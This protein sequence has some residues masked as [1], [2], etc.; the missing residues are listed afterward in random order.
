M[1]QLPKVVDIMKLFGNGEVEPILQNY[2][3]VNEL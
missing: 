1:L 2:A 3:K